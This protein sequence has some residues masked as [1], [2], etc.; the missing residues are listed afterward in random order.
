[1]PDISAII[2]MLIIPYVSWLREFYDSRDRIVKFSPNTEGV[3]VIHTQNNS[4][5]VVSK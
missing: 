3:K 1:M 5:K 2:V 4:F